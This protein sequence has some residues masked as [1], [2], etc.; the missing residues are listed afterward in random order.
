MATALTERYDFGKQRKEQQLNKRAP[1]AKKRKLGRVPSTCA[2]P[3]NQEEAEENGR[4][5]QKGEQ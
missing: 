1:T 3:V 4:I 2:P 5:Q